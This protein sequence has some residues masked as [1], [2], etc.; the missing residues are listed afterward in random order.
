MSTIA[1]YLPPSSDVP[2]WATDTNFTNGPSPATP[3][4]VAPTG[5]QITEGWLP[6]YKPPAQW[7]NWFQNLLQQ[8]VI[9]HSG[10]HA[11]NWAPGVKIVGTY[12]QTSDLKTPVC[13]MQS[14]AAGGL[15]VLCAVSADGT[16]RRMF[17]SSQTD[18]SVADAT[19]AGNAIYAVHGAVFSAAATLVA[20]QN[21]GT[22]RKTTDFGATWA[23]A[24]SVP[25]GKKVLHYFGAGNKWLVAHTAANRIKYSGDLSTWTDATGAGALPATPHSISSSS[26]TA[27][28]VFDTAAAVVARTTDGVTWTTQ[29]LSGANHSWRGVAYNA[30]RTAW[31]AVASDGIGALSIDDGLSW[32]AI[33]LP[34]GAQD[35]IGFGRHF[36]AVCTNVHGGLGASIAITEDQGVTWSEFALDSD[37]TAQAYD[38]LMYFDGRLVVVGED[39]STALQ[40]Q[41]SLRAPWMPMP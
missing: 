15:P 25:S 38:R 1:K 9:S 22:V 37:A 31:M 11:L 8:H 18:V 5:G 17:H 4:K 24:G 41:F 39:A 26:S 29:T 21:N 28:L 12:A 10:W 23:A 40:I 14:A 19:L 16:T 32:T 7:L 13:T 30:I 3:T 36:V 33:A 2:A 27:L 6:N 20:A 34:A 35:V